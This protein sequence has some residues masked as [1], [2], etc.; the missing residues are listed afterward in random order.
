MLRVLLK[1]SDLMNTVNGGVSA[2]KFNIETIGDDI[3][4]KVSNPS[5]DPRCFHFMV[6]NNKLVINV[7]FQSAD[8]GQ[9]AYPLFSKVIDIPYY[10][11]IPRIEGVYEEGE[12]RVYMPYNANLPRKPWP[13]K[14]RF[15]GEDND[16]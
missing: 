11:D 12:F 7:L 1:Q 5:V 2:T 4:I 3:V 9:M 8:E 14:M 10:V 6:S 15:L 13:V 16:E